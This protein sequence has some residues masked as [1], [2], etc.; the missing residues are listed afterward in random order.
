MSNGHAAQWQFPPNEAGKVFGWSDD[1][2]PSNPDA[3]LW[4]VNKSVSEGPVEYRVYSTVNEASGSNIPPIIDE[5]EILNYATA[6]DG[7][8]GRYVRALSEPSHAGK[9]QS[10]NGVW[11]ELANEIVKPAMLGAVGDGVADDTA[12]ILA[13]VS[14]GR[15]VNWGGGGRV[16]RITAGISISPTFDLNWQ[17]SG[18]KILL[19]AASPIVLMMDLQITGGTHLIEGDLFLDGQNKAFQIIRVQNLGMDDTTKANLTIRDLRTENARLVSTLS[20]YVCGIEVQGL[21]DR[22]AITRPTVRNIIMDQQ[23]IGGAQGIFVRSGST[24]PWRAPRLCIIEDPWVENVY[25]VDPSIEGD[26]DGLK[27]FTAEDVPEITTPYE[28]KFIVRGGVIKNVRGRGIKSQA[29]WTFVDGTAFVRTGGPAAPTDGV[30]NYEIEFQSG[31]GQVLNTTHLYEDHV[32]NALAAFETAVQATK[33]VPPGL[34]SGVQYSVKGAVPLPHVISVGGRDGDGGAGKAV[35]TNITGIGPNTAFAQIVARSGTA[36]QGFYLSVT[37]AL[38]EPQVLLRG[39]TNTAWQADAVFENVKHTGGGGAKLWKQSNQIINQDIVRGLGFFTPTIWNVAD[40]AT[41]LNMPG[42]TGLVVTST[43]AAVGIIRSVASVS[44]GKHY[45]EVTCG[46]QTGGAGGYPLGIGVAKASASL[47]AGNVGADADG[48][49]YLPT[50]ASGGFKYNNGVTSSYGLVFAPGD[51]IS[52]LLDL[53]A[54]TLSFWKNGVD[55]GVA[56]SGLSGT[57]FAAVGDGSNARG[58]SSTANFGG[59]KFAYNRPH[60]YAAGL[61]A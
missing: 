4:L 59:S 46:A 21:F 15:S 25:N 41:G 5:V 26:Q 44:T 8:G 33:R 19:D 14:I 11:W 39:D 2:S 18:A 50:S 1:A 28:T 37:N 27:L 13:T 23:G 45:W 7:G 22:I 56:F 16:Y 60:G 38:I 54:G 51:I 48:Y 20:T 12:A 57:F 10:A 55:Q 42:T 52:V 36:P 17:S 53:D 6:G 34:L 9:F 32:P 43:D 35:C 30:G 40:R 58:A 24:T 49:G 31:C 3:A 29:D 47:T 61:G